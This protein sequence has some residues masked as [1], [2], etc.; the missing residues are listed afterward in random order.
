VRPKRYLSLWYV[1]RRPCTYLAS[2]LALSPNEL[3]QAST[4]VSSPRSTFRCVQNDFLSLWYVQRKPCTYLAF[5]LALSQNELNQA[6]TWASSPRSTIGCVQN[7]LWAYGMFGANRAPILHRHQHSLQ[8]DQNEIPHD[9]HHHGVPLGA[10]KMISKDVVCS[11]QSMHLLS[12]RLALSLNRLNQALTWVSSPRSTIRCVQNDIWAWGTFIANRA[13]TCVKIST[14]SKWSE[15][16]I[17]L[18]LVT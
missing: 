11:A 10:S 6:S 2:R 18:S 17:H 8:M 1:R 16:S 7:D 3:N 4:W 15:S 13:P 14:I 5:R 12:S 9:S